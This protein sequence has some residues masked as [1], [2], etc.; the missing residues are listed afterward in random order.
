MGT[1]SNSFTESYSVSFHSIGFPSEWGQPRSNR[2]ATTRTTAFPFNWF[3]QRV[4]TS[5]SSWDGRGCKRH[6]VSIQLVSPAS[7][8][9]YVKDE[10]ID[11]K[12]G[13]VSIQLVSPASGDPPKRG[14]NK[15]SWSGFHS[16]GFPSEWGPFA[17]DGAG[18]GSVSIQLVSPASGD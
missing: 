2:K 5:Q 12:I 3:P 9:L 14:P 17:V 13:V 8:D 6:K 1:L 15:K 11:Q 4:G 18:S 10:A 16:I 7:G